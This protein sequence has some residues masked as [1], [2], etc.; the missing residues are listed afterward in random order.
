MM[1]TKLFPRMK[2]SQFLLFICLGITC[3]LIVVARATAT[4]VVQVPQAPEATFTVTSLGDSGAG[5]LRQ[6][7]IDAN[8]TEAHDTINFAIGLGMPLID[9]VININ[10][11]LPE[12]TKPITIQGPDN[13]GAKIVLD[14]GGGSFAGLRIAAN[15]STVRRLV[16]RNCRYG[17]HV[18]G[19]NTMVIAGNSLGSFPSNGNSDYG[20]YLVNSN[21]SIIGGDTIADRNVISG[22]AKHGVVISGGSTNNVRGNYIGVDATGTVRKGNGY[23]GVA[24]FSSF[25]NTIGG[26]SSARRNIISG[27]VYNGIEIHSNGNYVSANYIGL[28]AAG[29]QVIS[30]TIGVMISGSSYNTIG[31]NISLLRNVVSGNK[32]G[33]QIQKFNN[34]TSREN[35]ILG[36][37]IGTDPSGTMAMAN[38]Q[39]V[40]ISNGQD[41]LIGGSAL[42]EGNLISGNTKDG[43]YLV[44]AGTRATTIKGNR[45]GINQAGNQ[46]LAN[47]RYGINLDY[48]PISTHIGGRESSAGNVISGNGKSGIYDFNRESDLEPSDI[49]IEGNII[50]MDPSGT[51]AIPNQENGITLYRYRVTVGGVAPGAGNTIAHNIGA[52][53]RIDRHY[54]NPVRG[55][56][57]FSNGG[58]GIDLGEQGVTPN[59]EGDLDTGGNEQ[60]NFRC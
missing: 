24:I 28:D 2:K 55:N 43:I 14:C 7:I 41:N 31:G 12:I 35:H 16:I 22:N 27:N 51:I 8:A 18:N 15:S 38:E 3:T 46:A 33:I 44:N 47:G 58:L 5:T 42:G 23:S 54:F 32:T 10:T 17:I 49:V 36:N 40:I 25:G 34:N 56:A 1:M 11:A 13:S 26:S 39:G 29:T 19:A 59:D 37:F 45:I 6:A 57:I 52:G 50:G 53:V 9:R 21:S 4:D 60:Q 48:G 30:N 20:I